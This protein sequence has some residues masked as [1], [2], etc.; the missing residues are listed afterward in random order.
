MHTYMHHTRV[1]GDFV[2]KYFVKIDEYVI[3]LL[4]IYIHIGSS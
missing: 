4:F 2:L 1:S 3:P